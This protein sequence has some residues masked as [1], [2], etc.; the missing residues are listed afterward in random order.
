MNVDFD[1]S[2]WEKANVIAKND[3]NAYYSYVPGINPSAAW[4]TTSYGTDSQIYYR[5]HIRPST[6]QQTMTNVM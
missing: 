2:G 3:N 1:D 6:K 5:A 4:I